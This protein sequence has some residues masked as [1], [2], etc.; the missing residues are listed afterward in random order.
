[1]MNLYGTQLL[2]LCYLLLNNSALAEDALQDT[3]LK[4][5]QK[6][7]TFKGESSE[8]TWLT[9]IAVNTCKDYRR[10]AWFRR[11]DLSTPL[12]EIKHEEH[13]DSLDDDTVAKT[14]QSLCAKYREPILLYYYQNMSI[15]EISKILSI[16][17]NTV[18]TRLKRG[19]ELLRE[20]LKELM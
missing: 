14:I 12:R 9:R 3:F 6:L 20:P 13:W 11:V 16:S 19:R 5:Y 15:H 1:M 18:K 8:K 4:A 10:S 7:H 2:R 17:Q